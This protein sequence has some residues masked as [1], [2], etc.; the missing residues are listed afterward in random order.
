V[1]VYYYSYCYS[2]TLYRK[3]AGLA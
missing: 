2:Q 3:L 1:R